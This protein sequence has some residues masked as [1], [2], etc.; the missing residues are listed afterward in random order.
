M[1][2]VSGNL[3]RYECMEVLLQGWLS[4]LTSPDYTYAL[5]RT[6]NAQYIKQT[7][8]MKK[9]MQD[10]IGI[11]RAAKEIHG[12]RRGKH[13]KLHAKLGEQVV[14]AFVWDAIMLNAKVKA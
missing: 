6:R 1:S 8:D 14:R 7:S 2:R 12:H 11:T 4:I 3:Q 9:T 5:S 10:L 13:H